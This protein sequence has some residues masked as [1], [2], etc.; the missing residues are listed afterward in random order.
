MISDKHN[1]YSII[2]LMSN[3]SKYK[4]VGGS[5]RYNKYRN[6]ARKSPFEN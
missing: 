1:P 4:D 6:E 5:Q 3:V 2:Y